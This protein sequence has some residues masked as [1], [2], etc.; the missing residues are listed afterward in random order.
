MIRRASSALIAADDIVVS[1]AGDGSFAGE[2]HDVLAADQFAFPAEADAI[3]PL[4]LPDD[5]TGIPEA[6]DILAA[7][8]FAMPSG[9]DRS[10]PAQ[11]GRAVSP[12]LVIAVLL[13]A[14]WLIRRR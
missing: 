5:P 11:V 6:H 7:E 14:A 1:M 4:R 10:K 13:L 12:A 2:P 9:P 8:D 3:S